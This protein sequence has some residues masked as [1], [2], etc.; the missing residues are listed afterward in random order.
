MVRPLRVVLLLLLGMGSMG[1]ARRVYG[2][3]A[4]IVGREASADGSVLVGHNEQNYGRRV[5][6]FRRIPRQQFPAGAVVRLR[7]GGTVAQASET[8]ALLWSENPGLEFSDAYLNEHGVAVVSDACPTREDD[9]PALV[10]RG[11]IR[12]GGI[13]YMLRRLVAQR[14]TTAREGVRLAGK[15]IEQFGYVDSGRTYVIAD[16]REAWLLAVV[17]GRRWVA[18]RVPDDVVVGL[19]NI[20]LIG[21]VD[22]ADTER[23]LASADL[24]DYAVGRGWFDPAG[25]EPF[26]FRKVYRRDR[27]DAPDLRRWRGRQLVSAERIPWPPD[28][29]PPLGLRPARK[30][31]VAA[32]AAILRDTGGPGRT[33]S[34]PGTQEGAVFQLRDGMP[35]A[36]GC[37]YW[38]MTAEPA[39]S[40]LLPFYLGIG[41][42]PP[43]F[44]PPGDARAQL[45]LAHHFDPPHGTFERG[46]DLVWWAF[47][48]LQDRVREDFDR[49]VKVVRTVWA[50]F[51][52]EV[53]AEQ[54]AVE[55]KALRLWQSDPRAAEAYLTQHCAR[56]AAEAVGQAGCLA[57]E[58]AR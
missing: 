38:R 36:I 22:L 5:L 58:F 21:E 30:M 32:V 50:A 2:C 33:L 23:F 6:H 47:K 34:T 26:N 46:D 35:R 45:S 56:L 39:T 10:A 13:G 12:Q 51:E 8:A 17:R 11:E 1:G 43:G 49:R 27:R 24:I 7:R 14:A 48:V 18:Q 9:Y 31:T 19:P 53:F 37:I 41:K 15:L 16:P 25:G 57:E 54:A 3:Y 52:Q 29:P 28:E 44:C 4:V 20:H 40:V 55:K 42:T